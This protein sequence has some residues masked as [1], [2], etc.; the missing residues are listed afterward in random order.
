MTGDRKWFSSMDE[1]YPSG[2]VVF[3]DGAKTE[4]I[5]K[6]TVSTPGL[7]CLKNVL[8]VRGLEVSLLSVSQI[9]D[10]HDSVTFD[11]SRCL[12]LD[13]KGRSI[14]RGDRTRDQCYC[15]SAHEK[16]TPQICF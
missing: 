3:G 2:S 9:V 5:G 16:F 13:G 12:I 4:I 8:L 6:G 10:E 11:K 15:I 7:P 1:T 14:M